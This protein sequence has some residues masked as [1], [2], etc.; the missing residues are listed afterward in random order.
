MKKKILKQKKDKL[1]EKPQLFLKE[2]NSESDN[3][4]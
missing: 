2:E 4:S 3:E 1:H